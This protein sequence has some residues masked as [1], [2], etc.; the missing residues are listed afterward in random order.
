MSVAYVDTSVL[1]AIAFEE[2]DGS[3]LAR[4]L[5][6]FSRL[7]ASNLLE[8]EL[9][10]ACARERFRFSDGLLADVTWVLPDRSLGPEL[11]RVL[12]AGY[13][14]GA[15]LWHVA[16]ALYA[17]RA[18]GDIWFVTLDEQQRRVAAALGFRA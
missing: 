10:A 2:N 8:A 1:A 7:L 18:P 17:T 12:N 16:C 6:D 4:R 9:R 14:R 13:L 15:D 3:S 5:D 11:D